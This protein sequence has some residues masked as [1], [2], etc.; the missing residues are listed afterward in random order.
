[1]L[2]DGSKGAILE[3]TGINETAI[4]TTSGGRVTLTTEGDRAVRET[5]GEAAGK[6]R[7]RREIGKRFGVLGLMPLWTFRWA[8]SVRFYTETGE[9]RVIVK[10]IEQAT[11]DSYE[12]VMK[13]IY[14]NNYHALIIM[15]PFSSHVN[16]NTEP[17]EVERSRRVAF[18]DMLYCILHDL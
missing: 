3:D 16:S 15:G 2:L 8:V 1:M 13:K 10:P 14:I 6:D 11:S 17:Q 9:K 7:T 18:P 4:I 5:V 12:C